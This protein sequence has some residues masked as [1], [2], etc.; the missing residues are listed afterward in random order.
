M[1]WFLK[2]FTII[3]AVPF[4]GNPFIFQNT[5]LIKEASYYI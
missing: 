2:T 5:F 1:V 4:S 3:I